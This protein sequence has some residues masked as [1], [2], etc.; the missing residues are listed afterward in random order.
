[1]SKDL[2]NIR[3]RDEEEIFLVLNDD[4][5]EKIRERDLMEEAEDLVSEIAKFMWKILD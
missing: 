5:V 4:L 1:M 2:G 3:L